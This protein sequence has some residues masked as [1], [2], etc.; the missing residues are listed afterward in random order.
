MGLVTESPPIRLHSMVDFSPLQK[1]SQKCDLEGRVFM[2]IIQRVF[3]FTVVLILGGALTA[4]AQSSTTAPTGPKAA[5][6]TSTGGVPETRLA[7]YNTNGPTS[8]WLLLSGTLP[9]CQYTSSVDGSRI[10][11]SLDSLYTT[12]PSLAT[13]AYYALVQWNGQGNGNPASFYCTQLG[14]SDSF[15]GVTA[16]GGGWVQFGSVDEVLEACIFPDNS[17]ID[18]WGLLYHSVGIIRGTD[19]A[20][21]LKYSNPY[22]TKKQN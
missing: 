19:L 22:G 12:K 3:A 21:I 13:L 18:S 15:G 20:P 10:Y 5:Y 9:F 14:G 6:C 11:V 16:A 17:T 1:R 8:G 7:Y 4:A 2:R